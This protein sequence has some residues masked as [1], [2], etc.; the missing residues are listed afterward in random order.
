MKRWEALLVV[1]A[2]CWPA[3]AGCRVSPPDALDPFAA[4]AR[5]APVDAEQLFFFNFKPTGEMGR[6]WTRIQQEIEATP[7]GQDIVEGLLS[8]FHVEAYGL[9]D[10]IAGPAVS[11]YWQDM[12][13]A[14]MEVRDEE[15]VADAL[16]QQLMDE[17]WEEET[18]SGKTLHS[19]H[20][21]LD[22]LQ[23]VVWTFSDGLLFVAS[24]QG[25][26]DM[27]PQFKELVSL[28]EMDSLA[29]QSAWETLRARL[30]DSPLGL[31]VLNVA[32][33]NRRNPPAAGDSSLGALLTRQLEFLALAAVPQAE[34][35]RVEIEGSLVPGSDDLPEFR[36]LLNLPAGD[37]DDWPGLPAN[38]AVALISH[39]ASLFLPWVKEVFGFNRDAVQDLLGLDLEADLFAAG[40]PLAGDLALSVTPPLSTQAISRGVPALQAIFMA[41]GATPAHMDGVQAAMQERGVSFGAAEVEGVT[42]HIQLGTG[43]SGF[44]LSYGFQDNVLFLGSSP[45]VVGQALL[46][47]REGNGLVTSDAFRVVRANLPDTSSFLFFIDVPTLVKTAET[48]MSEAQLEQD[49]VWSTLQV[50]EAIGLGLRLE[51]QRLEGAAYLLLPE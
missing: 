41:R 15:A 14:I 42:L 47:Q 20:N 38:T 18:F 40:G 11:G 3:L 1:L 5:W 49:G 2:L 50:F 13:Y 27:L 25:G 33:Q 30:P 29:G 16:R 6:Y 10:S 26:A 8:Q 4:L 36:A 7:A 32:D 9:A 12:T 48:N 39:D 21:R 34:G 28:A 24:G 35:M 37:P 31:I 17:S 46:A 45:D 43:A 19:G 22:V 51:S 23:Q 44:A